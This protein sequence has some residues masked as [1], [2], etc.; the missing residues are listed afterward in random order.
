VARIVY[1]D[2]EDRKRYKSHASEQTRGEG[3]GTLI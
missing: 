1:G 2:N 3:R